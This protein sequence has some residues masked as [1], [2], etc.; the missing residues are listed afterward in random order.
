MTG[1][2]LL[3]PGRRNPR[4]AGSG[5]VAAGGRRP[6][7]VPQSQCFCHKSSLTPTSTHRVVGMPLTMPILGAGPFDVFS[8]PMINT[9]ISECSALTWL[10][11]LIFQRIFAFHVLLR[12]DGFVALP[13]GALVVVP[14]VT[15]STGAGRPLP[16]RACH[17]APEERG[18]DD[19]PDDSFHVVPRSQC[20]KAGSRAWY[21]VPLEW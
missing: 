4:R 11:R 2:S 19:R 21:T 14:S 9:G 20:S 17:T 15:Q 18:N 13:A 7:P 12:E 8:R 5:L 1:V 10:P 3:P 6:Q 16:A